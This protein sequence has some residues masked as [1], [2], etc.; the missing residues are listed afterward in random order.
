MPHL[1]LVLALLA[2]PEEL[3]EKPGKSALVKVCG[4]CHAPEAVIGNANTKQGWTELV[5][6]MIFRGARA[7]PRERRDIIAYLTRNFPMRRN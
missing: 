4:S 6:E 2:A 1:F 5:D 7:T 3:P